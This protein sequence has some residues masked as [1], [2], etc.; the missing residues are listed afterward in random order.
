MTDITQTMN[1]SPVI[2]RCMSTFESRLEEK[3]NAA[4]NDI[5]TKLI[6]TSTVTAPKRQSVR[7]SASAEAKKRK[8]V[9]D[10]IFK[11]PQIPH[12]E[13]NVVVD[14]HNSTFDLAGCENDVNVSSSTTI[15]EDDGSRVGIAETSIL[16]RSLRI[17]NLNESLAI[18]KAS[19]MHER[20]QKMKKKPH[21]KKI[22]KGQTDN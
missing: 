21:G 18:K 13:G 2:R 10:D 16:R 1:F 14:A 5:A 6:N 11:V 22:L 15:A 17:Q 9:D 8:T 3:I 12:L 7:V 4:M 20:P 19:I